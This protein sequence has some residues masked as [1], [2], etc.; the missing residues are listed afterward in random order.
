MAAMLGLRLFLLVVFCVGIANAGNFMSINDSTCLK[1]GIHSAT[2]PLNFQ[3]ALKL[4]Q[5]YKV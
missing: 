2:R 1:N 3:P 4:Q 5:N